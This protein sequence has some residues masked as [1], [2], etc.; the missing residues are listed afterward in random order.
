MEPQDQPSKP[1]SAPEFH[2]LDEQ[3]WPG[4][5]ET[6]P[7]EPKYHG[8]RWAFVGGQGL[9]AG[10]SVL[11]FVILSGMFL[12][13]MGSAASAFIRNVLHEKPNSFTP[14]TA[15]IGEA[16]SVLA[17]LGAGVLM[18]LI[19]RR[20]LTDYNLA[21][22]R[23]LAHFGGGLVAGFVALSALVGAMAVGGWAHF[24]PVTL[25]GPQ[26]A[27]FGATW[28]AAFLLTGL[29]EEGSF[30][31]YLQSTLTRGI[32]FWWALGIVGTLSVALVL[33]DKGNGAW[34]L[35]GFALL[36]LVPCWL[37]HQK[38]AEGAGFWQ[39]AWVTSTA[40][41]FV[42]TGNA[43]ETWIGIFSAA[44]IGFVFCVSIRVTG[45]AWW[46]IG[47]HA[48]W[49]WAETYFYG[50]ADSGFVAKGHLLSTTPTGSALWSGG[51]TGPEGSLLILPVVL[52]LL[53]A[54]VVV[55][56]RRKPVSAAIA[57]T[58]QVPG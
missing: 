34:G 58:E 39:A 27:G 17:I 57:S 29:F 3:A 28:G 56:G 42:H 40:F 35:Y 45:S 51:T 47:C 16:V 37:L 41:G 2:S 52:L 21:G 23:R 32:N 10:W 44:A 33:R 31:C 49:D 15:V 38:K 22:Q 18:A 11:L 14:S 6:V 25:T 7:E 53:A 1:E 50:T 5:A 48:A 13:A 30:R 9:R 36:G 12:A 55:Y 8:L 19:E 26:I 20:R 24:G 46:A 54:L 4:L 43:G